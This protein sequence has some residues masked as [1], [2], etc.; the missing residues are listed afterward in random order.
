[1]L[2]RG[3]SAA[4]VMVAVVTVAAVMVAALTVVMGRGGYQ[5][6]RN[7][8]PSLPRKRWPKGQKELLM[9]PLCRV[10]QS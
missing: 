2:P 10:P 6:V 9:L 7:D 5:R 4:A 8:P 1:M 3:V